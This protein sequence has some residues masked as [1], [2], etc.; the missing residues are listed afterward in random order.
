MDAQF[1]SAG[2]AALFEPA[3]ELAHMLAFEAALARAQGELGLIPA[4]AAAIIADTC[5]DSGSPL[6]LDPETVRRAG[7]PAIPFVSMLTD[8]IRS[9]DADAAAW[10]HYGATSQ[11]LIDTAT[12]LALRE[13]FAIVRH[14]LHQLRE[15]MA[16]LVRTHARTP[17]LARTLLQQA[18]PT[19]LG[20]KL[21]AALAGLDQVAARMTE[22]STTHFA[23]QLGGPVGTLAAAGAQASE[24][25]RDVAARLGLAP[26]AICWH[27]NRVRIAECGA[28]L[29]TLTGQLA[30]IARDV[31]LEMQSE[32]AELAEGHASGKGGSSAMPHKHNPVDSVVAIA[33]ATV[34]PQLAAGLFAAMTQ[35]HERGAGGWHAEWLLLPQLCSLSHGALQSVLEIMLGLRVDA[36]RMR[37]NLDSTLGLTSASALANALAPALGRDV[38]HS[39]VQA[40]SRSALSERRNLREIAERNLATFEKNPL[41]QAQL[42]DAFSIEREVAAAEARALQYLQ[43]RSPAT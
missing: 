16:T 35:E 34:T 40:W 33:A 24:L 25:V 38:A 23:L 36:E 7:N 27:T 20:Y 37:A 13:T 10:V 42:A 29:A 8:R 41:T 39:T 31:V 4:A 12:M 21:A 15:S 22:I 9:V 5:E 17:M 3:T 1:H 43:Q 11:D 30:K 19:T 2:I 28:V 18:M 14:D 6:R 32:V 26:A